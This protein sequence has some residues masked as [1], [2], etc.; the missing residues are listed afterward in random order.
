MKS[1]EQLG[2]S[3]AFLCFQWSARSYKSLVIVDRLGF[4]SFL[5]T[6]KPIKWLN[7]VETI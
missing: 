2:S 3:A 7:G 5:Y 4:S 1:Y 6:H